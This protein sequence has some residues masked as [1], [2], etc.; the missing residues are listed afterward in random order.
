MSAL[1][2]GPSEWTDG[3][4]VT[5]EPW[6]DGHAV[7]FKIMRRHKETLFVHPTHETIPGYWD[8]HVQALVNPTPEEAGV[9]NLLKGWFAYADYHSHRY[10]S[11]IGEDSVLGADW[12]RIGASIRGLLNGVLGRLDAGALDAVICNALV[13]EGF[14]P[15]TL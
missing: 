15:N 3:S 1:H 14:D 9:V 4:D 7:G 6:T 13:T 11:S 2:L 10:E 8:R 12:A 5:W